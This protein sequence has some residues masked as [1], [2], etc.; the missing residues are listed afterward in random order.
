MLLKLIFFYRSWVLGAFALL[1]LLGLTWSFGLL[2]INEGTVVMTYLFT[3]FN[4]FQGMF[5]FIF[6][7]ALQKKVSYQNHRC[8]FP[9]SLEMPHIILKKIEIKLAMWIW[10]SLR[11]GLEFQSSS[12]CMCWWESCNCSVTQAGLTWMQHFQPGLEKFWGFVRKITIENVLFNFGNVVHISLDLEPKVF[13]VHMKQVLP[14]LQCC[15]QRIS[16]G[17]SPYQPG[18]GL[19]FSNGGRAPLLRSH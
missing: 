15:K 10:S 3:V 12:C 8:M 5:I 13:Y 11:R 17:I 14:L 9:N 19:L 6:H 4:A 16:Y 1:C 2:F 18:N 7:C